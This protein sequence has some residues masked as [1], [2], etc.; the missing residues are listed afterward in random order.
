VS[1][2]LEI[3][4]P[5]D[6]Q[7]YRLL[8]DS[9]L[10][11]TRGASCF[12]TVDWLEAF[13]NSHKETARLRVLIAYG[14][15]EPVGILPLVV[16]PEQH[17]FGTLDVCTY[18]GETAASFFGPIGPNPTAT[19]LAGMRHLRQTPRDWDVL[20]LRPVNR[21]G[22]DHGRTWR[23]MEHVGYKTHRQIFAHVPVVELQQNDESNHSQR[24]AAWQH[25]LRQEE[26]N[27]KNNATI[28]LVRYRPEGGSCDDGDPRWDLLEQ[29]QS[30]AKRGQVAGVSMP[31]LVLEAHERAARRGMLDVNVLRLRGEP[32]AYTYNYHFAGSVQCV[33][34]SALTAG[35]CGN[36][37]MVLFG[38][39]L[40]DGR[41]RGDVRYDLGSAPIE[42]A[43]RICTSVETSYRYTHF[44]STF[45]AQAV[46]LK[47]WLQGERQ[48]AVGR[49]SA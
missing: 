41:K 46:R 32:V 34:S 12:H 7:S 33:H 22:W 43:H 36:A 28:E 30:I 18:P 6:L 8:W 40:A 9:L 29:C 5:A 10:A 31:P 26:A 35:L 48:V 45:R 24:G 25:A 14:A 42:V 20:D 38:R 16:R 21:H 13:A 4:D 2:I 17:N 49:K 1:E 23:A 27:F 15:D 37:A 44:P 3:N 47:R 39:M 19:L 11:E